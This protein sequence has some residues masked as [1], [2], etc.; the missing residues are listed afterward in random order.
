MQI[1]GKT[2][3][4][5]TE[6]INIISS[7]GEEKGLVARID[8]GATTSS[9]DNELASELRLGPII[10]IKSIRSAH[11]KTARPVVMA[12]IKIAGRRLKVKFTIA[13]R[14]H[15]RYKILI[16]QNILKRGFLIDASKH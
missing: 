16:G 8:T 13:D 11:G 10:K 2:I 12:R 4:G 14:S 9:I 7:K 1:E 6:K 5:F 15:M 3:I